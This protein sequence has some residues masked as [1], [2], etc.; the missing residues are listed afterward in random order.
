MARRIETTVR[1]AAADIAD[2][3]LPGHSRATIVLLDEEDE[4]RIAHLRRTVTDAEA[5]EEIEAARAFA[6]IRANLDRRHPRGS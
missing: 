6:E 3:G 5:T 2:A 1:D 4:A